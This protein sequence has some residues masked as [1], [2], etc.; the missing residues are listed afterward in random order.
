[1][2]HRPG[3]F[4]ETRIPKPESRKETEFPWI[5]VGCCACLRWSFANEI[6][7]EA[8]RIIVLFTQEL[9]KL[10]AVAKGVK[11]PRSKLAGAV[12]LFNHLE[13]LLAVGR[14]LDVITQVRPLE[15]FPRL[16]SDMTRY[17]SASYVAE[18]LDTLVEER[19]AA[20]PLFELLVTVLQ[21][22][23][24]E[25]DPA[26]LLRGFELKLLTELG[27]GPELF[28]C[29]SCGTEVEGG[30]AGFSTAEGE[31]CAS[32]VSAPSGWWRCHRPR[33][34][35]MRDLVQMPGEELARRKLSRRGR[36]GTGAACCGPSWISISRARCTARLFCR[37]DEREQWR[38]RRDSA[39]YC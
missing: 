1:M 12:Q 34:Q 7:G 22:L 3:P 26:T 13:A 31:W 15:L 4:P 17:A 16:R 37:R 27:Y 39:E 33:L 11:R 25:G 36:R 29:V 20:P 10:S 2:A 8:D 28:T 19:A 32:A 9:G 18:L 14:S 35:A 24:G 38:D 6:L 30:R 5:V 23:D 21:G